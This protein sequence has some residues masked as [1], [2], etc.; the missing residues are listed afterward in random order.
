M[1]EYKIVEQP[2][3]ALIPYPANAR[4]HS[5]KQISQIAK[6]IEEFGFTNPVLIDSAGQ[7]IAGHGRVAAAKQLGMATLPT[8]R[9]EHLSDAQKRAYIIADNRLAEL[10]GW[11]Q[12][13]LAIELQA[14]AELD[15]DFDIEITGFE[16]AEID[17]VI[18][19]LAEHAPDEADDIPETDETASP[20]AAPGDLWLL[21]DHRLLC[22]NALKSESYV[23]LMAG[24]LAEM[25]ITDPPYN[26]P[27]DGHVCGLGAIK[28]ADFAM[29]SGEMSE[30]EFEVFLKTAF[31]EMARFTSDGALHYIFMDWRHMAELLSAGRSVY[32]DLVNLCIWNKANGGMGSFYRSKHELVFVFKNGT[33]PHINNVELGRHG[34]NRTNVWD[35]AGVNSLRKGRLEELAMHPTV[36][37]VQLIADAILDATRRGG[38]V[39][40]PFAGSGST[41]L[42]AERAGR[43]AFAM[44]IDPVYV[45]VAIRRFEAVTGKTAIHAASE[46]A[47]AEL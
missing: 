36:K 8:I 14:L 46:F 41:I 3:S 42:A 43:R 37:P 13:I 4:T 19:G 45:D 15:L 47:F 21:G 40:D 28:H 7:I 35:Y 29:A 23:E 38:I 11:D 39:L 6:S 1:S 9:I 24:E 33:K 10:A 27:I 12:E 2:V 34:R 25:V 22:R 16:T 20:I 31:G 44:E 26:V 18:E 32:G 17:L 30:A 5:K